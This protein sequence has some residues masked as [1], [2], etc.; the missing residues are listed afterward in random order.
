MKIY[1]DHEDV[2]YFIF[3]QFKFFFYIISF[4]N[5]VFF[6]LWP[7]TTPWPHLSGIT[8]SLMKTRIFFT[9]YLTFLIF[10]ILRR[11]Y[12]FRW[13]RYILLKD[14][15]GKFFLYLN[16]I[17]NVLVTHP[18]ILLHFCKFLKLYHFNLVY[19]MLLIFL[20][21]NLSLCAQYTQMFVCWFR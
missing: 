11:K 10:R 3:F 4:E 1:I 16:L 6:A 14:S 5:P 12:F 17:T 21:I 8:I 20:K 15:I 18:G 19:T 2:H 9:H 13:M 7:R